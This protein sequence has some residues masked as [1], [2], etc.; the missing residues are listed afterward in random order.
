MHWALF[1][2]LGFVFFF[3]ALFSSPSDSFPFL[4]CT[5]A[6]PLLAIA[7]IQ[8]CLPAP[9]FF[10]IVYFLVYNTTKYFLILII[11][12]LTFSLWYMPVL[13]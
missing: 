8:A 12:P 9:P 3:F 4:F 6:P 5:F 2:I 1:G 7:T 10:G 13:N 11:V